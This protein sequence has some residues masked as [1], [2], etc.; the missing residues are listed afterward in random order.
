MKKKDP[1]AKRFPGWKHVR[2]ANP[3][4]V[5]NSIVTLRFTPPEKAALEHIATARGDSLSDFF[6]TSIM[7]AARKFIDA[8]KAALGAHPDVATPSIKGATDQYVH[9]KAAPV[10]PLAPDQFDPV[11]LDIYRSLQ[12]V[13]GTAREIYLALAA[14]PGYDPSDPDNIEKFDCIAE[15]FQEVQGAIEDYLNLEPGA[16]VRIIPPTGKGEHHTETAAFRSAMEED[17]SLEDY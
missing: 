9:R 6:R 8:E 1:A 12:A 11:L 17:D 13:G 3:K 7:S 10:A 16:E 15:A 5:R 2:K 4:D 14:G